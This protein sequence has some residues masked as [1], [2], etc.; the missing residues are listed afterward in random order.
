MTATLTVRMD[1]ALK[2]DFCAV[3]NSLGLDAPT[4]VRMLA[5]Q[6]VETHRLPLSLS[7]KKPAFVPFKND[8]ETLAWSEEMAGE[9]WGDE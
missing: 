1:A 8:K 6:T 4:A 7:L 3:V 2:N 9:W 5:K